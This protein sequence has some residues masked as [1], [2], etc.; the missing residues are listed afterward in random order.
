M[1]ECAERRLMT[2]RRESLPDFTKLHNNMC[3]NAVLFYLL[4]KGLKQNQNSP[5]LVTVTHAR[6]CELDHAHQVCT[7]P[8]DSQKKTA[9][10]QFKEPI[11]TAGTA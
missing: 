2:C 4:K 7:G 9:L 5:V 10:M 1:W 6:A 8:H 3:E 11:N